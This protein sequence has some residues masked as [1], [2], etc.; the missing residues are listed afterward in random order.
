MAHI[1]VDGNVSVHIQP[2]L[3][4]VALCYDLRDDAFRTVVRIDLL[5]FLP[6]E[7]GD[8]QEDNLLPSWQFVVRAMT[9]CAA[10]GDESWEAWTILKNDALD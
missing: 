3:E 5:A 4:P 7:Y 8:G 6:I 9:A 10:R 1:F 2:E